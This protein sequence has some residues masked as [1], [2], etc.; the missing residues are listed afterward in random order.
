M[1]MAESPI[2]VGI[3][4]DTHGLLRPEALDALRGADQIIHAGDIGTPEILATLADIAPVTAV[5]GNN[6][7][8]TW[9]D[10]LPISQII[11]VGGLKIF[12]IHDRKEINLDLKQAKIDIV[13]AGHSHRPLIE[14]GDGILF[15]NPGSAGPRRFKLPVSIALLEVSRGRPN[16]RI[17]QLT[18]G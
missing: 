7:Q 3:I 17:S 10:G 9:A 11:A 4:S 15:I 5:R 12:L 16:A 14:T 18:V 2:R 8:D 1:L 6:D 13:I